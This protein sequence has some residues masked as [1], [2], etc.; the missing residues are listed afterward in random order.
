MACPCLTSLFVAA[1]LLVPAVAVADIHR[2]TGVESAALT[3]RTY[4]SDYMYLEVTGRLENGEASTASYY[5]NG[6]RMDDRKRLEHCHRVAMMVLAKP[7][8]YFLEL[9]VRASTTSDHRL[10]GCRLVAAP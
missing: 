10:A 7:G 9:D 2:F 3:S 6:D 5:R 1:A 4:D 8:K